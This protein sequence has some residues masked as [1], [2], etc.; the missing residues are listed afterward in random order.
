MSD[1]KEN[2]PRKLQLLS[3]LPRSR[4]KRLLNQWLHPI[5]LMLRAREHATNILS[6]E[7]C[8]NRSR[9]QQH[10][11]PHSGISLF[12]YFQKLYFQKLFIDN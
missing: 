2:I 12:I 4:A 8:P 7:I 3:L 6:G 1:T 11:H 5:S 9:Q 10:R